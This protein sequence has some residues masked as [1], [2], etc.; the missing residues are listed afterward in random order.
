MSGFSAEWLALRSAADDRAR[1]T[2]L[3]VRLADWW[4]R[5]V[6]TVR[7]SVPVCVDLASG[8]GANVRRLAPRLPGPQHWRLVDVDDSLLAHARRACEGLPARDGSTRDGGVASVET[9]ELDLAS[10]SLME[11]L[12][13][14][15]LVTASALLDLVSAEWLERLADAVTGTRA[16]GLYA[17]DYD[18]R[19]ECTPAD[20]LDA[21]AH[22]AFDR[23]QRTAKSFGVALGPDAAARTADAFAARGYAVFRARSDWDLGAA[24]ATL[25]RELLRGWAHA[26]IAIEPESSDDLQ[27]WLDR[28]LAHVASGASRLRVGHEDLLV[29]PRTQSRDS[30]ALPPT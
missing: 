6:G 25:Q 21:R 13:G 23:H 4:V 8:T 16:A 17:L 27:R 28:R 19:R 10:A 18:G 22:V 9:Q 20:P 3:E 29:L 2:E 11:E 26:A 14:A 12:V 15:T 5:H 7:G 24:D 30:P 1:S